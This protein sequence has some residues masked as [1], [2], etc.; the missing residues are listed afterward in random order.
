[1]FFHLCV[2][3]IIIEIESRRNDL[4]ISTTCR[5][6]TM[7]SSKNTNKAHRSKQGQTIR[8]IK[9]NCWKCPSDTVDLIYCFIWWINEKWDGKQ[10]K[11]K[12]IL[13]TG[14]YVKSTMKSLGLSKWA[15]LKEY[16]REIQMIYR[17]DRFYASHWMARGSKIVPKYIKS[18]TWKYQII[19]TAVF[20]TG[21]L[22]LYKAQIATVFF[23][24]QFS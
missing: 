23:C 24:F 5:L 6:R 8:A 10:N 17:F 15:E 12:Q 19:A 20:D 22:I 1:M 16:G 18:Y 9:E 14:D 3:S 21:R 4:M 2:R 7:N 13:T 11:K